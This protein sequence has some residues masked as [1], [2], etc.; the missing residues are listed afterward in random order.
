MPR[1][2]QGYALPYVKS[3]AK[4][5]FNVGS[6][7][8]NSFNHVENE[9]SEDR[10]SELIVGYVNSAFSCEIALKYFIF[11]HHSVADIGTLSHSLTDLFMVLPDDFRQSVQ[12]LTIHYIN[13]RLSNQPPYGETNFNE[14]LD[15]SSNAFV[16][17]RYW[18]EIGA[19]GS[20]GKE[21]WNLFVYS[22][23]R[24]LCEQLDQEAHS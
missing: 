4:S 13:Q 5:Y 23:S 8:Y 21:S 14:D 3:L 22:L 19:P 7:I 6:S 10:L 9:M 1:H 12:S 16:E 20:K 17:A 2:I 18:F 15:S 11:I 24:A